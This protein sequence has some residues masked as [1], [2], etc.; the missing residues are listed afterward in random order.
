MLVTPSGIVMLV[1]LL[2]RPKAP[3][4]ILVTPLPIV[5]LVR[6][7][8]PVKAFSPMSVTDFPLMVA[9][10]ISAPDAFLSQPVMVAASPLISY[11]KLGLTGTSSTGLTSA[12]GS[13]LSPPHP[14]RS[15]GSVT[16]IRIKGKGFMGYKVTKIL[17]PYSVRGG[18]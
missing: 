8:Q 9:G 7:A 17:R 12:P 1:R 10:M 6:L 2:H 14:P 11:F 16:M 15:R 13:F 5:M 18:I 3:S 4:P